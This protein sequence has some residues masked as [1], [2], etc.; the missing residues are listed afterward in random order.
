ME[1]L[2]S[3]ALVA[4]GT[5]SAAGLRPYFTVFFLG[6]AKLL[7][8]AD[9]PGAISGVI[10]QIPDI[11]ADPWVLGITGVLAAGEFLVDKFQFFDQAW[12]VIHSVLRPVFGALI[13]LQVGDEYGTTAMVTGAVLG[14]A[15]ATGVSLGRSTLRGLVNLLPEPV[16]NVLTSLGEDTAAVIVLIGVVAVPPLAAL[17]G[18]V[19]LGIGIW[20]FVKLRRVFTAAKARLSGNGSTPARQGSGGAQRTDSTAPG[21]DEAPFTSM[22]E[23]LEAG[24]SGAPA[25]GEPGSLPRRDEDRL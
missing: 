1:G 3:T 9:A 18:L 14:G 13:G 21:R 23:I 10:T 19:M 22:R 16:T 24:A 15:T 2:V 11:V 7:I 20:L 17:V 4:I 8:P 5:G 25:A 6:V 12:D